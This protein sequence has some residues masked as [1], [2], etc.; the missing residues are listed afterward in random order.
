MQTADGPLP[1]AIGAAARN[2]EP[3]LVPS[4][5]YVDGGRILFGPAALDRARAQEGG[6]PLLSFK[7]VLAAR[8]VSQ[9]LALKVP[10]S[11]DPTRTFTYRDVLSL[12]LAYLDHLVRRALADKGHD[13]GAITWRYTSPIWRTH[14]DARA[15]FA[16]LF[17]EAAGVALTLGPT[18]T[19]ADGVSIAHARHALDLAVRAPKPGLLQ[20]EVFEASAA[21]YAYAWLC[22]APGRAIMVADM[23][24]G[25]TDFAGFVLDGDGNLVEV[26][27]AR[28]SVALAGDEIDAI[29]REIALAKAR[30]KTREASRLAYRRLAL[31][32]RDAKR[33]IFQNGRHVLDLPPNLRISIRRSEVEGHKFFKE[34]SKAL[35]AAFTSSL[36][37]IQ[38]AARQQGIERVHVILAGGGAHL[39]LLANAARLSGPDVEVI[40]FDPRWGRYDTLAGA[41]LPQTAIVIGGA[42]A[43]AAD[44][45]A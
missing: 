36:A 5:V 42:L 4:V 12:Y 24:A 6:E 27:E 17:D 10:H 35:R 20:R 31:E 43:P 33:K 18:L 39:P 13:A 22:P 44:T 38:S 32:A 3:Y 26:E 2:V 21:A 11:V 8:D 1:L 30:P 41:A 19:F 37:P 9:A 40:T 25:T 29:V 16:G 23:G 28:Q 14:E 45:T 7:S 15:A 34:F